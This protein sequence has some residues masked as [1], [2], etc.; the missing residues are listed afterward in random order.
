MT[1]DKYQQQLDTCTYSFSFLNLLYRQQMALDR[2]PHQR[3]VWRLAAWA[4]PAKGSPQ[5]CPHPVP[6]AGTDTLC[7]VLFFWINH[8]CC[9]CFS[10][11]WKTLSPYS[12]EEGT[13]RRQAGCWAAK[14]I[15]TSSSSSE[16]ELVPGSPPHPAACMA[17]EEN[18]TTWLHS[19]PRNPSRLPQLRKKYQCRKGCVTQQK[20]K[21]LIR[22]CK[23]EF[24]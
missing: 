23:E 10:H 9:F 17:T 13:G 24:R 5:H 6:Q 3:S 22:N 15:H 11:S 7:P 8:H 21:M 20:P 2:A 18:T 14:A 12:P 19:N 4:A 16:W 1:A